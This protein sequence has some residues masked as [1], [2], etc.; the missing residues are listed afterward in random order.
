LFGKYLTFI[1]A[2]KTSLAVL[3]LLNKEEVKLLTIGMPSKKLA[4]K[5]QFSLPQEKKWKSMKVYGNNRASVAC[6][7]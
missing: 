4:Q 5:V 1:G 6:L 7:K 2:N 3:S